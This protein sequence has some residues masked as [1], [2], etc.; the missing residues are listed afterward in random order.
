MR[1]EMTR[2]E[3]ALHAEIKRRFEM[4]KSLQA[5]CDE[6]VSTITARF[7][8]LLS[9]AMSKMDRRLSGLADK[10]AALEERFEYEKVH[11]PQVD[12]NETHI[13]I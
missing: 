3:K 11:I 10:I 8:T 13:N 1:A 4:N 7:E 5:L 6:N 9:D 12:T 2:L